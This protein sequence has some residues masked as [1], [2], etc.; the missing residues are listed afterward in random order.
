MIIEDEGIVAQDLA[1]RLELVGYHIAGIVD[2]GEEALVQYP[3]WEPDLLMVDIQLKGDMDGIQTVNRINQL[4]SPV[5]V[6]YLTALSDK[7][8]WEKAKAT[9]PAAYLTKP[10]R[11]RDI[12]SAIELAIANRD[13]QQHTGSAT[14]PRS[15]RPLY[16]MGDRCFIRTDSG[17]FEKLLFDDL[18]YL[19]AD[20]SYCR[21]ITRNRDIVL[22]ESLNQLQ[23]QLE[24]PC[25]I[26][27]HRSYVVNIMAIDVI[28]HN[29][30]AVGGIVLP[31]GQSYQDDFFSKITFLR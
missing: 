15:G 26:R 6:V 20:R 1:A 23:K 22:A 18:L 9:T 29:S 16:R 14:D 17:R 12:H 2:N 24:H 8:T 19:E 5:L 11:E 27:I 31:I 13:G 30:V 21:I 28:D 4:G 3:L 10:F 25:L 7:L